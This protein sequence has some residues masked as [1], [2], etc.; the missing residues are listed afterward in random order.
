M[1]K[2]APLPCFGCGIILLNA[3][4]ESENQPQEATAFRTYGHYGSTFWDS[5]DGEEIVI[6]IC[7]ECLRKHTERIAQQKRYKVIRCE[8]TWVVGREWVDRPMVPFSNN[9]DDEG[10]NV[11]VDELGTAL[12]PRVE[13]VANVAEIKAAIEEELA[14]EEHP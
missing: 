8:K 4:E 3:F 12:S 9:N 10:L 5:F 14:R 11:E 2:E 7:D 6:N 1:S 13:W